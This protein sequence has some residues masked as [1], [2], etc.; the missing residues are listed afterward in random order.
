MEL[1]TVPFQTLVLQLNAKSWMRP[2]LMTLVYVIICL[3]FSYN[4]TSY[5]ASNAPIILRQ[6]S[7]LNCVNLCTEKLKMKNRDCP[8][9]V[10][11][12]ASSSH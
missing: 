11:S 8:F 7:S 1:V 2:S 4:T 10:T 3:I 6:E 5:I 9:T 12:N